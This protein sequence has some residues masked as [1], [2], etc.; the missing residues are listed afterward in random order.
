M[1]DVVVQEECGVKVGV[2]FIDPLEVNKVLYSS[3]KET[4]SK[5]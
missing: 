4:D 5:L 1:K 3:N 2:D